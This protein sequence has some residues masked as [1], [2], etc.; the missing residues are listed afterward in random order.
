MEHIISDRLLVVE[1]KDDFSFFEEFLKKLNI[2]DVDIRN[3]GG[4]GE[5][6]NKLPLLIKTSGFDSIKKIAIVIDAHENCKSTFESIYNIIERKMK[7]I[8]PKRTNTYSE[9]NPS[10]GIFIMPDN[11]SVGSIEELCLNTIKNDSSL[12][13][14]DS[15]IKCITK[16]KQYSNINKISRIP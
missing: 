5:Y 9:A 12:K 16:I 8:P 15:F 1:G 3:V 7:L 4:K 10:I 14:I 13:C 6:K 2:N 11:C